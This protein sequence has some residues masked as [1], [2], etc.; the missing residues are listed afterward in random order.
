MIVKTTSTNVRNEIKKKQPRIY[1]KYRKKRYKNP[2]ETAETCPWPVK[3]QVS[4]KLTKF[5]YI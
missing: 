5:L 2:D 1:E 3:G 4:S